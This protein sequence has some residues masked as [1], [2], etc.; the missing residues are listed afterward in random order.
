MTGSYTP[1]EHWNQSVKRLKNK[2]PTL[3]ARDGEQVPIDSMIEIEDLKDLL[4]GLR[5]IGECGVT[6]LPEELAGPGDK[7]KSITWRSGSHGH[8]TADQGRSGT[9]LRTAGSRVPTIEKGLSE[10]L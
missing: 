8:C 9:P 1:L 10:S 5:L 6:L 4:L 7:K 3:N 2:Q